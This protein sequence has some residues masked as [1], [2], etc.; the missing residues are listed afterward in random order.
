MTGGEPHSD[1]QMVNEYRTN[2][3]FFRCKDPMKAYQKGN[4]LQ[5]PGLSV[6]EYVDEREER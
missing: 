5:L 3:D 6:V 4:T 2:I 1:R